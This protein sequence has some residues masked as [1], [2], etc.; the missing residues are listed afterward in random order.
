MK[1][2]RTFEFP[3]SGH[4]VRKLH[5]ELLELGDTLVDKKIKQEGG[6]FTVVWIESVYGIPANKLA[7]KLIQIGTRFTLDIDTKV[8][9]K[10]ELDGST[11]KYNYAK[12]RFYHD[13]RDIEAYPDL[14]ID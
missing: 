4:S 3:N 1:T 13:Y 8:S 12:L 14:Y 5:A 2:T 9:T 7:N 10:K 11:T 6:K